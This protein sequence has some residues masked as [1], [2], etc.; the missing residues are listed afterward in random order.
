[1]HEKFKQLRKQLLEQEWPAVYFFKFISPSDPETLA[2][3]T[4]L[5]E[6]QGTLSLRP[7]KN[8]NFISVS[9]KEVMMSA[10]DVIDVYV[11]AA[12]IKGVISL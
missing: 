6:D 5:F 1:M 8:G 3:V 12:Q 4:A 7:S 2:K 10:D 11:K 9:V